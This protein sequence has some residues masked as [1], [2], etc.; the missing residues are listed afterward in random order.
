MDWK[1]QTEVIRYY[2][3]QNFWNAFLFLVIHIRLIQFLWKMSANCYV[4]Q[5]FQ[6]C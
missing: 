1:L 2:I 5:C 4:S 3:K 6:L